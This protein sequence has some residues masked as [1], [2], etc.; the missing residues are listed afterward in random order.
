MQFIQKKNRRVLKPFKQT[1]FYSKTTETKKEETPVIIKPKQEEK[2]TIIPPKKEKKNPIP[3]PIEVEEKNNL[4]E[5][6]I[7]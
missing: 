7:E 2:E 4:V 6:N 3:K 1:V 5:E